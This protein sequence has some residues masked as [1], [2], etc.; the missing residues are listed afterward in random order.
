MTGPDSGDRPEPQSFD[1]VL[2]S[3]CTEPHPS[4]RTAATDFLATNPGDP[5]TYPGVA[6]LEREVIDML[7]EIVALPAPTGYVTTGGTEANVQAV[8]AARNLADSDDPTMVGPESLHF[9]FRKAADILDVNLELAPVDADYRADVDAIAEL[10]DEDT[11][12]VVGVAGT[13]EY[14]RVDPIPALADLAVDANARFHVDAAWGGFVLP[15]THASWHFGHAEIDTMAVDPHKMGQAAIP[16]GGL[17][18]ADSAT[19]DALAVET[20]YLESTGQA[21]LAG[22]RSGA[23]VASAH[24]AISAQW[25]DGYRENYQ[26]AMELATWL[27][28]ELSDRGYDVVEPVN[29][30]VAADLPTSTFE[31]LKA[32]GWRISRTRA[33]ELRVV[34]MPH[35]TRTT[36]EGFLADLDRSGRSGKNGTV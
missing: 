1:R 30:I 36:L 4:A 24:A 35:V 7:G 25:P 16:A 32:E 9:S 23:G 33:G 26:Q 21:T 3:M 12:L 10:I 29:P 14:G 28:E 22:T 8:R 31:S 17:L 20:P 2:S 13:T 27:G 11:I 6:Q 5:E 19:L 15:F 18:A 34:L